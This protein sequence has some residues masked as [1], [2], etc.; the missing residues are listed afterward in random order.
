MLPRAQVRE[1]DMTVDEALKY[2]ISMG[3]VAPAAAAERASGRA[4]RLRSGRAD[5]HRRPSI[6]GS[7]NA[8]ADARGRRGRRARRAARSASTHPTLEI[9]LET[10]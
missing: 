7:R 3:V 6:A 4:R 10:H 9:A 5:P 1:L 8:E 2:I